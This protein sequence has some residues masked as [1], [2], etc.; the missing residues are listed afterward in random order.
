MAG[1]LT[2]GALGRLAVERSHRAPTWAEERAYA[3]AF[4]TSET[5]RQKRARA[6][7]ELAGL[8]AVSTDR[9]ARALVHG[10]SSD[11]AIRD[12]ADRRAALLADLMDGIDRV[13]TPGALLAWMNAHTGPL[14]ARPFRFEGDRPEGDQL[15]GFMARARCSLWWRRQL[16]RAAVLHRETEANAAGEVCARRRQV[17]V[18]D[19]TLA[20][21]RQRL[22]ETAAMMQATELENEA[23]QVMTLA[24]LS[25]TTTANKAIRRGELMTR[26][27]GCE[28]LA[29]A[30]GMRGVFL[31]LTAPSRFHAVH[32]HGGKNEKHTDETPRDAHAW[33]CLTWARA[34][35]ALARRG[36]A[37]FGFRVAEPHH[38]GCPHWHA[39]LWVKPGQLWR[40]VRVLKRYW[41]KDAGDEAGARQHRVK[42][43][44]MQAGGASGYIA[45]YVAKNIDDAGSIGAEGHRDDDYGPDV[46]APAQA[47]A[48]GGTAQR[49][50]AWASAWGIRQFQAI[51]Q[52][53]VTVWRELRRV[54]AQAQG[55]AS[56][57]LRHAFEAVNRDGERR[58][59]WALYV[60]AQ[61]GLN[62][63]R[64]YLVRLATA[65]KTIIGRYET[66]EENRPIGVL[67]PARPGE[68]HLS[69]R[70]EWKPRGAWGSAVARPSAG[71]PW[72]R[73]NNCTRPVV[74][75]GRAVDFAAVIRRAAA[76][77]P[78]PG[79]G[80]TLKNTPCAL[81]RPSRR[82]SPTL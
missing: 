55:G 16:R 20:R 59:D 52:P 23:G 10:R 71:A 62:L 21:H 48:F 54:K 68:L 46:P 51:G 56:E 5:W 29:E 17:Y 34:R 26:I 3:D 64:R 78:N 31:T 37:P 28:R 2:R 80:S 70:R 61:G 38:D 19:D 42:A 14:Q 39:L 63:G 4:A 6:L 53:P 76:M 79:E 27:S 24:D 49:V 36:V 22:A 13:M 25:A 81:F 9:A 57:R 8:S 67:D 82:L 45:K 1:T 43:V 32:R 40:L 77:N 60:V 30:F 75:D 7:D 15:R 35:A 41:L 69:D 12:T 11:A 33:L 58:A 72:T 47:D 18:T 65:A 66:T 74:I 44:L 73:V 50:A